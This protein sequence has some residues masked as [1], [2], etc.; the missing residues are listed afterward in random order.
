MADVL[1]IKLPNGTTYD[2]RDS[3]ALEITNNAAFHNSIYRGKNLGQSVSSAQLSAIDAGTFEDMYVGD[4]WGA[5]KIAGFDYFLN[6]TDGT[7]TVTDHHVV[8]VVKYASAI[9]LYSSNS[10]TGGFASMRSYTGGVYNAINN[11]AS[12]SAY[13]VSSSHLLTWYDSYT[14]A[15]SNGAPSAGGWYES[16]NGELM[17]EQQVF[18][19]KILS[20]MNTGTTSV[21]NYSLSNIQFPL[22]RLAPHLIPRDCWLRDIFDATHMCWID[23]S[24]RPNRRGPSNEN[25]FTYFFCIK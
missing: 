12:G 1:Q 10:T 8:L 22:Y 13:P 24:G 18:G 25:P 21:W 23:S 11:V 4:Y 7:H 16:K 15:S 5:F 6:S 9:K 20:P 2:L 19:C 14:T 3:S 17:T